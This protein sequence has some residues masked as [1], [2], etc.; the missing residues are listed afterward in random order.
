MA[1]Q[2]GIGGGGASR[3]SYDDSASVAGKHIAKKRLKRMGVGT[4]IFSSYTRI[5]C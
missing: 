5:A 4:R 2:R 1:Q 3:I